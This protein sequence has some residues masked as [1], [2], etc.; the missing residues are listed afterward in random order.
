MYKRKVI[1]ILA[2]ALAL[3]CLFG[4]T[5][6]E[7]VNTTTDE[8]TSVSQETT[9]VPTTT[10]A[11][12]TE[13]KT[14]EESTTEETTTEKVTEKTTE[15]VTEKEVTTTKKETTTEKEVTTTKKEET[16][17]K[18]VTYTK[19]KETVYAKSEVNIRKSASTNSKIVGVLKK[20]DK[21]TR[22]ATGDN[23]WSKVTYNGDT[24]YIYS[25]YLTTKPVE[26]TTKKEE[27]TT[28]KTETTTKKEESTT[29]N[30]NTDKVVAKTD[31]GIKLKEITSKEAEKIF[32]KW[33]SPFYHYYE[34]KNKNGTVL[35]FAKDSE[36]WKG[37]DSEG[38]EY[39]KNGNIVKCEYCG[40]TKG[41]GKNMCN[42]CSTIFY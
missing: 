40:K 34:G 8:Q 28:K 31:G 13:E 41:L 1:K 15:P 37:T 35:I 27:T 36:G 10:E 18:K 42:G 38:A 17:E 7:D 39:N 24:C 5:G 16:T 2:L 19:K 32:E 21:I 12:T 3:S 23:G 4:C 30:N 11:S 14:T 33:G 9:T 22:T 6:K 20:G 25:S 26:T 29:K